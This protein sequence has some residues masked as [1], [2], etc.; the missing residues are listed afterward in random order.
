MIQRPID[1]NLIENPAPETVGPRDTRQAPKPSRIISGAQA[2]GKSA[3]SCRS[4]IS[5][6]TGAI[7]RR[8]YRRIHRQHQTRG[9]YRGPATRINATLIAQDGVFPTGGIRS[10]AIE[11][12]D[13]RIADGSAD[14][15]FVHATLIGAGRSDQSRDAC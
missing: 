1:G 14:D 8:I 9:R 11:L 2:L 6:P 5:T 4:E 10:R 12:C 3:R 13:Y 15:A 7:R